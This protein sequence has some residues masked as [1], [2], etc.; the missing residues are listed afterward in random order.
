[1]SVAASF[2]KFLQQF[3]PAAQP[4]T[5]IAQQ[6]IPVSYNPN[7]GFIWFSMRGTNNERTLDPVVL[8]GDGVPIK[9]LP[10]ELF[11]DIEIYH[12]DITVT[13]KVAN[14][15]HGFDTYG[16][17]FG[18]G[19]IGAMF[20]ENQS[21]DYVAQIDVDDSVDLDYSFL[22]IEIRLYKEG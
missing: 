10:D 4:I 21:D 16:G 1:M 3:P 11:F 14:L 12:P 9:Q 18:D 17:S 19:T 6:R 2:R 7:T 8:D 22:S 13:E 5:Q 20:V 15:L